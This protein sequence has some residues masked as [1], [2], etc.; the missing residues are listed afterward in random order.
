MNNILR[1]LAA[2]AVFL[3]LSLAAG[4]V[5]AKPGVWRIVTLADGSKVRVELRGDEFYGYWADAQGRGFRKDSASNVYLELSPKQIGE[6]VKARRAIAEKARAGQRK[7]PR[8]VTIGAP[9]NGYTGTKKGII[10]LVQFTDTKFT[11]GH[12]KT[13]YNRLANEVGF[14]TSLGFKGSVKDYFLAQSNGQFNLDFDIVGPYTLRHEVAYYGAHS[15]NSNDVR[16]GAM[17]A[18]AVANADKDVDFADYDWDG[19]G[20]VDQVFVLFAG[21]GEAA[22]GDESTI[23]PHEFNLASSDYGHSYPTADNVAVNTYA[24][25]PEMTLSYTPL[26]YKKRVD[27]IGT[28]C[29]EFSHCL[30]LPDMYDTQGSQYGMGTYDLM[31]QGSYNGESFQPPYYSAYEKWY[32]GWATPT[33]LSEAATVKDMKPVAE[34]GQTFVIYNDNHK[35][36]YYLLENRQQEGWD[37]SLYGKG[38]MITHVDFD[39]TVWR[40]NLVNANYSYNDGTKTVTLNDHQRCTIFHADN[41]DGTR[42]LASIAGD[43]YPYTDSLGN[44]NNGLSASTLPSD[45][46]YNANAAGTHQMDKPVT[47]I[48]QNADGTISFDFMGGSATNVIDGIE[49]L[50]VRRTADDEAVYNLMGMRMPVSNVQN[51]QLPAGVYIRGGKKFVVK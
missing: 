48:V 51:G 10:I 11:F 31:D 32:C 8:R 42:T 49:A 33:E 14:T 7:A 21:L 44:V 12:N 19:D 15:G 2:A 23:W 40:Y 50:N 24:C 28:I 29:H 20:Y 43:L 6:T 36:E 17:V 3:S 22:G 25:G 39:A 16:P 13:F 9:N 1:K 35:D 30:G 26:G 46:L 38:L 5:P 34:G 37:G 47:N 41:E 18:E 45:T 4:A 27:G